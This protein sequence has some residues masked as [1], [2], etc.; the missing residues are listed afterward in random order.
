LSLTEQRTWSSNNLPKI[1]H[2]THSQL[3]RY[4]VFTRSNSCHLWVN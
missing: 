4:T 2:C 3:P 1:H